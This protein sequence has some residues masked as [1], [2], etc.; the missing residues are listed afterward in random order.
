MPVSEECLEAR[1][2]RILTCVQFSQECLE[3]L[4]KESKH[5]CTF[6]GSL[7]RL[8]PMAMGELWIACAGTGVSTGGRANSPR[9]SPRR[10]YKFYSRQRLEM[11]TTDNRPPSCKC[12]SG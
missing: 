8:E 9:R 10:V 7:T 1:G 2:P 5:V 3:T 12:H 6:L 11:C 4:T